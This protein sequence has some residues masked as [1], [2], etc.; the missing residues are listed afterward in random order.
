MENTEILHDTDQENGVLHQE[1]P[2][3]YK[4]ERMEINGMN[5]K[6]NWWM[7]P[8]LIGV[9]AI[10]L[11]AAAV[12]STHPG[13]NGGEPQSSCL[14]FCS[15]ANVSGRWVSA[16]HQFSFL[17]Y[18]D[19]QLESHARVCTPQGVWSGTLED[20]AGQSGSLK[21]A[22]DDGSAP[23][24]Q[25]EL[26][27]TE[28][29]DDANTRY[30]VTVSG[31]SSDTESS[32]LGTY[33]LELVR[34]TD[35]AEQ[36]TQEALETFMNAIQ[37]ELD[38]YDAIGLGIMHLEF[39]QDGVHDF[40]GGY[41]G[42]DGFLYGTGTIAPVSGGVFQPGSNTIEFKLDLASPEVTVRMLKNTTSGV[43]LVD[44]A[45]PQAAEEA[46]NPNT[47]RQPTEEADRAAG[48]TAAPAPQDTAQPAAVSA[49]DWKQAY[50]D[51]LTQDSTYEYNGFPAAL[52][53]Y[54]IDADG[55]GIPEL[56]VCEGLE[57]TL[58]LHHA[59]DFSTGT[60]KSHR[61]MEVLF[62]P[63]VATN[64]HTGERVLYGDNGGVLM[65]DTLILRPIP[66]ELDFESIV[67]EHTGKEWNEQAQ[68]LEAHS[69]QVSSEYTREDFDV[70]FDA[71]M[72]SISDRTVPSQQAIREFL[73]M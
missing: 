45:D 49:E 62:V 59:Y 39:A 27:P 57:P 68:M 15:A 12:F 38:R 43:V 50:Y 47:V 73:G 65:W 33:E 63:Y 44:E 71:Q 61:D 22:A 55:N 46:A 72:L 26:T 19:E 2:S 23:Y 6:R 36:I 42:H 1:P 34:F 35:D 69:Q 66:E 54:L 40:N 67:L 58:M 24:S 41:I 70:D 9:L 13:K 48:E 31:S 18:L 32:V 14:W 5:R 11:G 60:L 20:G 29:L 17:V 64:R 3:F 37:R 56:Y 25:L 8:G 52:S 4:T 10:I 16:D 53:V 7:V 51:V 28:A 21:I 30:R